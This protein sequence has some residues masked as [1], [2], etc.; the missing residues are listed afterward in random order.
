MTELEHITNIIMFVFRSNEATWQMA[1]EKNTLGLFLI[2]CMLSVPYRL[3]GQDI[4][5]VITN[6]YYDRREYKREIINIIR[7]STM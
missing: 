3:H 7:T 1:E 4:I 2:T 6:R 5:F